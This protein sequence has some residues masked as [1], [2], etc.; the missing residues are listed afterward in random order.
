MVGRAGS[1]ALESRRKRVFDMEAKV[2]KEANTPP[3][4]KAYKTAKTAFYILV[5]SS[6]E[7]MALYQALRARELSV[8]I[9]PAPRGQVACCGMSI[10]VEPSLMPAVRVALEE[11]PRLSYDRVVEVEDLRDPNRDAY[12]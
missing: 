10:M 2:S 9:A 8:R 1:E 11:D 6:T 5:N 7:G 12:C 3:A 4:A